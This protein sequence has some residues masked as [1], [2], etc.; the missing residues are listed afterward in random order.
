MA[1]LFSSTAPTTS[2]AESQRQGL[3]LAAL[4]PGRVAVATAANLGSLI[5]G[6]VPRL[7]GFRSHSEKL[8]QA[9][10]DALSKANQ[11]AG[12]DPQE[13]LATAS[14]ILMNS[15][16]FQGAFDLVSKLQSLRAGGAEI[17]ATEATTGLRTAQAVNTAGQF[18]HEASM[19]GKELQAQEDQINKQLGVKAAISQASLDQKDQQFRVEQLQKIRD[20]DTKAQRADSYS[21]FVDAKA[22][23]WKESLRLKA[24]GLAIQKERKSSLN[25]TDKFRTLK[26]KA[27]EG[28]F[29]AITVEAAK[30]LLQA[31]PN[32]LPGISGDKLDSMKAETLLKKLPSN[33][34]SQITQDVK[35]FFKELDPIQ[36]L[37]QSQ[38]SGSAG[39]AP[40]TDEIQKFAVDDEDVDL[41]ADFTTE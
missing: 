39:L 12:D 31:N 28:Y 33:M 29:Q 3:S 23:Y 21:Q 2:V 30:R 14:K 11:I 16:D 41:F 17:G 15:G 6:T 10:Q 36:S 13:F 8:A 1:T 27:A 32:A 35:N 40:T 9:R 4:P 5:G 24:Q 22:D 37:L 38:L 25:A 18:E 19:Q 26:G 20:L 34:R 7:F